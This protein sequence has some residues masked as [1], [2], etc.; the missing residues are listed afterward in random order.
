MNVW[1]KWNYSQDLKFPLCLV[2][3]AVLNTCHV[4]GNMHGNDMQTRLY[5]VKLA[6]Y[7]VISGRN[8][9]GLPLTGIYK[10][11]FT[12]VLAYACL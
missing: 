6:P 2:P 5:I 9:G 12:Q 3:L 11:I 10:G 7:M 8:Q 1:P 4:D